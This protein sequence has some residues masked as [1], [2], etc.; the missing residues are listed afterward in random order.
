VL[1]IR[2]ET[3]GD[4]FLIG[5]MDASQAERAQVAFHQITTSTTID[6]TR[7]DYVSSIG[8]SVFVNAQVRLQENGHALRL[9]NPQPRVLAV[10]HFAGLSP[11]F[12]L[13]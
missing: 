6:L 3:S 4:I 2:V 5:R 12:G 7:L 10:I 13:E 9:V 8:L 1:E 11:L